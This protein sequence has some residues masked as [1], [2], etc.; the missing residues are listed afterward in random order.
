M[1]AKENPSSAAVLLHL[2]PDTEATTKLIRK[3]VDKLVQNIK[4]NLK[5]SYEAVQQHDKTTMAGS[6]P[7]PPSSF[8]DYHLPPSGISAALLDQRHTPPPTALCA[9]GGSSR[10]AR[11]YMSSKGASRA[12]PYAVPG[13]KCDCDESGRRPGSSS[14]AARKRYP[15]M[16]AA[17]KPKIELDDPLEMLQELIRLALD[18]P[19]LF[20]SRCRP[21]L[22]LV[23]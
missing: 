22:V 10:K 16:S 1:P 19:V 14:W 15:S 23:V 13:G 7:P 9:P 17:G 12:S 2:S 3:D 20:C 21:L 18:F 6:R 11:S 4:D 5:L 8:A